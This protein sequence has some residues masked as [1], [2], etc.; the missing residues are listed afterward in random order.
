MWGP[1]LVPRGVI[2]SYQLFIDYFNNLTE[3]RKLGTEAYNYELN[4]LMPNQW[5]GIQLSA[6]T[7]VGEGPRSLMVRER[8]GMSDIH[9]SLRYID[10]QVDFKLLFSTL[11]GVEGGFQIRRGPTLTC[12]ENYRNLL[13]LYFSLATNGNVC[14]LT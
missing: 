8:T 5:I 10:N 14:N 11:I 6:S 7:K 3:M 13:L 4:N 1:P 2:I 9:V 12:I